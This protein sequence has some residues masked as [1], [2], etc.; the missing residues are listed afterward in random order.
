ML[1]FGHRYLESERFY[2]IHDIDAITKTPPSSTLFIEFN[3]N[4]L[5]IIKHIKLNDLDFAL[6]VKTLKDAIFGENLGAKYIICEKDIAKSI[7]NRAEHYLFDAKILCRI[8]DDDEIEVL[9]LEGI[10]GVVY[11]DAII[12]VV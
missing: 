10:D 9:A 1:I 7:Q 6:E 2:H 12:K 5:D 4:N 8:E 11:G 3:E